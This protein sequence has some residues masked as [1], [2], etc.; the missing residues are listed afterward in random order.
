VFHETMAYHRMPIIAL[1]LSSLVGNVVAYFGSDAL[2]AEILP[3]ASAGELLF[4]LLYTEPDAGSDLAALTTRA[5]E[6]G[7]YYV[8]NGTK[9]YTSLGHLANYGLLAARTNPEAPKRQGISLFLLPLDSEGVT[10]SPIYTMGDG[11]VNEEVF[12]DVRV[13]RDYMIGEKDSGWFVL[14]MALGL[15]RGSIAGVAAQGR[16]FLDGL[17]DL[18]RET[19]MTSDP[20]VCQSLAEMETVLEVSDLLNWNLTTLLGKGDVPITEAAMAKLYSSESMRRM[21]SEA[22]NM[23]GFAGLLRRGSPGALLEGLSEYQYQMAPMISIG[24]GSTEIMQGIIAR[25]GLGLAAKG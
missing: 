21:G 22:L 9:I 7:D 23:L 5:E 1:I 24:A 2:K 11:R 20:V 15:E 4:C 14:T 19:G 8:V 18:L 25:T 17:I 12:T 3:R 6:D 10:V 16:A 13:H